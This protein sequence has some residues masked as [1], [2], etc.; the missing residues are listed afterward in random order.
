MIDASLG[1]I[2]VTCEKLRW[3][4]ANGEAALKPEKRA[5]TGLLMMHKT[6]E[7]RYEPLGIVSALV[8]WNYPVSSSFDFRLT[9]VPQCNGTCHRGHLCWQRNCH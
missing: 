9:P 3:L 6:A 7:I 2:L 8:S 1:E 4:I 5:V